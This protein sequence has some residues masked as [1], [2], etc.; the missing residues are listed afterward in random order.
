[1]PA[2]AY[3]PNLCE[4][5]CCQQRRE[6]HLPA[7][8]RTTVG[9]CQ[10]EVESGGAAVRKLRASIRVQN[11]IVR[12]S[13]RFMA[14]VARRSSGNS[15]PDS[16]INLPSSTCLSRYVRKLR[17]AALTSSLI[18]LQDTRPG[19]KEPQEWAK[20]LMKPRPAPWLLRSLAPLPL[21][22]RLR[23]HSHA[24]RPL[25]IHAYHEA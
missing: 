12:F 5:C 6:G 13:E 14:A 16:Y 20:G 18:V 17:I 11:A 10:V 19:R 3:E 25:G 8:L 1:M 2:I 4:T 7:R 21:I 23:D 15:G 24:H 9:N 22:S